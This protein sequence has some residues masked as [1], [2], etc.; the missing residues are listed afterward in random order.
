MFLLINYIYFIIFSICL[1]QLEWRG[2]RKLG[3]RNDI[4]RRMM[5]TMMRRMMM[6]VMMMMMMMVRYTKT[7][8]IFSICLVQ[9]IAFGTF[10]GRFCETW[11]PSNWHM[12]HWWNLLTQRGRHLHHVSSFVKSDVY[13]DVVY[14]PH[15]MFAH[16]TSS[17]HSMQGSLDTGWL[18]SWHSSSIHPSTAMAERYDSSDGH[19]VPP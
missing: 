7:L 11:N 2:G 13:P 14:L 8:Y 6:M 3:G 19:C 5:R 9:H 17:P 18:A 12:T 1:V 16:G 4:L 15:S 10:W